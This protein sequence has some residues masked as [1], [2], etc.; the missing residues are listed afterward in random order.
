MFTEDDINKVAHLARMNL[1]ESLITDYTAQM[2][3]IMGLIEQISQ[4]DTADIEPMAHP[5]ETQTQ[6]CRADVVSEP[7][8]RELFQEGAPMTE[9]GLYLVPKVID[10]E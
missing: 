1:E 5:L 6:R 2:N 7:N 3:K 10:A 9:A 8:Q 4:A